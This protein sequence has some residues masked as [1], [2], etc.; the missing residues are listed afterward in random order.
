MMKRLSIFG[1]LF[2]RVAWPYG[3]LFGAPVLV[4][5]YILFF[6]WVFDDR[7]QGNAAVKIIDELR[8]HDKNLIVYWSPSKFA[9][10]ISIYEV[11]DEAR[12]LKIREWAE[13]A[14]AGHRLHYHF[15]LNFYEKEVWIVS[16]KNEHGG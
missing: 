2:Y 4:V 5:I 1:R 14:K 11:T 13:E 7:E 16:P 15:R 12:Q 3:I 9:V 10:I 8:R 6:V